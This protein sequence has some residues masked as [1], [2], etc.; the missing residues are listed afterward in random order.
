MIIGII[1]WI[2]T[3][4]ILV[5]IHEFG[6]F[7]AA[8]K[9]GVKVLEFGIWI[10]PRLFTFWRDK[11]WTEYTLN[12][13]PFGWF[14]RLK[15]ETPDNKEEFLAK[16][17]FITQPLYKKFVILI[18][19]V[20]MNFILAVLLFW[21]SFFHWIKPMGIFPYGDSNSY[22]MPSLD[23]AL[24]HWLISWSKEDFYPKI[25]YVVSWD[26]RYLAT[27]L[28]LKSWDVILSINWN[29][30]N[31]INLRN[32]IQQNCWQLIK[33]KLKRK[34]KILVLSWVLG[35]WQYCKLWIIPVAAWR[36]TFKI[37]KFWFFS[38]FEVA[39]KEVFQETKLT[40]NMLGIVI[41]NLL[42]FDKEKVKQT[43]SQFSG[44]VWAVKVWEI[45]LN[46][47]WFWQYLVFAAMIS[48]A[49]AIFNILP[50]PALD[51]WRLLSVVIQSMLRLDPISY[52]KIE[53]R[54][55]IVFFIILMSFWVYIMWLDLQRF[56]WLDL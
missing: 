29:E 53:A 1:I 14:V 35:T 28:W 51:G 12:L 22:L 41:K 13:L 56:W 5:L 31:F 11:S 15:W 9:S 25:V 4:L 42:T 39:L 34:D 49:L 24:S 23:F 2:L 7:I 18:G 33:L 36:I 46:E 32:V 30:V 37:V 17:S 43:I 20:F 54:L 48:L 27:K 44:P 10:P 55:N 52:F 38:S 19:G 45:I 6:H 8:K 50:I 3:F 16:D 40:F 47:Y 21:I 26:N